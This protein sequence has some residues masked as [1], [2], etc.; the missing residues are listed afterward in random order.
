MKTG[1]YP[2]GFG[3]RP[4]FPKLG[5]DFP[6]TGQFFNFIAHIGMG[7]HGKNLAVDTETPDAIGGAELQC[8]HQGRSI[9]GTEVGQLLPALVT[10]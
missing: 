2:S 6:S 10:G 4:A 7:L 8:F 5:D 9:G 3:E 1:P